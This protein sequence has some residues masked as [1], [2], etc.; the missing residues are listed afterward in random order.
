MHQLRLSSI[1]LLIVHVYSQELQ[2]ANYRGWQIIGCENET[3]SLSHKVASL[4]DAVAHGASL[5]AEDVG[6]LSAYGY[7]NF[8]KKNSFKYKVR[9]TLLKVA[10]AA[11]VK[12]VQHFA[13]LKDRPA[14][15]VC[16]LEGTS[17]P[18][19]WHDKCFIEDSYTIWSQASEFV[20]LCPK[21]W[22]QPVQ[23]QHSDCPRRL[24][25]GKIVEG[26]IP[27]G[28]DPEKPATQLAVLTQSL[29]NLYL[30]RQIPQQVYGFQKS[31]YLSPKNSIR[32]PDNYAIYVTC[33]YGREFSNKID[34][35]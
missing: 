7:T 3:E 12:E 33:K 23:P 31:M 18:R 29:V 27:L 8:F 6:S 10:T 4:L 9:D 28:T 17:V 35:Y 34:L 24:Q 20:F 26:A 16:V 19:E 25:N 13:P 2:A 30:R 5:A 14:S 15:V 32:N 11:P 21:F 1:Y 22:T